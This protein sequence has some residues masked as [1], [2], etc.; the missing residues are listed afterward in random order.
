[1]QNFPV[2]LNTLT[3]AIISFLLRILEGVCS[4]V[5]LAHVTTSETLVLPNVRSSLYSAAV[6]KLAPYTLDGVEISSRGFN[7]VK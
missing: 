1:M 2:I 3:G 6:D 7:Q 5:A 4:Q